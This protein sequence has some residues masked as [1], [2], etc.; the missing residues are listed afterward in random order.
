MFRLFQFLLY[1]AL[2]LLLGGR[3]LSRSRVSWPGVARPAAGV[4]V[5]EGAAAEVKAVAVAT[6]RAAN[7]VTIAAEAHVRAETTA[8]LGVAVNRTP[9]TPRPRPQP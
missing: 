5:M 6:M 1:S 7:A 8:D 3:W 9:Q 4:R 2:L